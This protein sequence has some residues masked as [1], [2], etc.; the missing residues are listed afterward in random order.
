MSDRPC[1][2][3]ARDPYSC[4]AR[5]YGTSELKERAESTPC[6]CCCHDE[7][8][9]PD[10]FDDPS[11]IAAAEEASKEEAEH[12]RWEDESADN[13]K[14]IEDEYRAAHPG[15]TCATCYFM[16]MYGGETHVCNLP[17]QP[18]GASVPRMEIDGED[19]ST[20]GDI[21]VSLIVP[22]DFGC[23]RHVERCHECDGIGG[24]CDAGDDGRPIAWACERCGGCGREAFS[25]WK[26]E[27][28]K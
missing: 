6:E 11:F 26:A 28:T 12:R 2:C 14:R 16:D 15:G 23:N 22:R 20:R 4:V 17:F 24:D 13:H 1:A 3:V 18:I 9:E 21:Q 7:E 10:I 27:E 19:V 25:A 8:D 5:R